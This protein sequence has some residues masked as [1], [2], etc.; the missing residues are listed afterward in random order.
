VKK[1]ARSIEKP[2][3][4]PSTKRSITSRQP[5][6]SQSRSNTKTDPNRRE[7]VDSSSPR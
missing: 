7:G 6:C 3:F 5:D 1:I 4:L 2:N